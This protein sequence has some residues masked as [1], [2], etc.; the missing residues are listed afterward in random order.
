MCFEEVKA[1]KKKN[2]NFVFDFIL[3]L[4]NKIRD[5]FELE[6]M[7]SVF[8]FVQHTSVSKG[9]KFNVWER[10]NSLLYTL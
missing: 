3:F 10:D 6:Y 9:Q 1:K 8:T 7:C 5:I 4:K 2:E